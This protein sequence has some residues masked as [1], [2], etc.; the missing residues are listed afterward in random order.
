MKLFCLFFLCRETV[1]KLLSQACTTALV[2][3]QSMLING[4][5][6]SKAPFLMQLKSI[7]AI[8]E[9]LMVTNNEDEVGEFA[10]L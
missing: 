9:T 4:T 10:L 6:Q 1:D 3:F 8:R 5:A 2:P 7:E